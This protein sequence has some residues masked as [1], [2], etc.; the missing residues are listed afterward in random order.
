[1][2]QLSGTS[3]NFGCVLDNLS[4]ELREVI[5]SVQYNVG[6]AATGAINGTSKEKLSGIRT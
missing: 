6:L 3:I 4:D 1:M 2:K 5:R